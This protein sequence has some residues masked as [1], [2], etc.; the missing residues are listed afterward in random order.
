MGLQQLALL[1]LACSL[2]GC[3][4][5]GSET[6]VSSTTIPPATSA[7][8]V[9]VAVVDEPLSMWLSGPACDGSLAEEGFQV[10]GPV[11]VMLAEGGIAGSG[12]MAETPVEIDATDCR[13]AA[14]LS[15]D[16][17]EGI[18]YN[19]ESSGWSDADRATVSGDELLAGG[20]VLDFR[21]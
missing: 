20:V 3:S 10:G 5:S 4:G 12:R 9:A 11:F 14:T 16:P 18:A 19:I 6:V 21:D 13:V 7:Q 8:G 17:Q 2:V 1:V 15:L